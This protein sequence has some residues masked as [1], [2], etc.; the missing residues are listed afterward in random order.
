MG[1][2]EMAEGRG[3][4]RIIKAR[5]CVVQH[6]GQLGCVGNGLK[7]AGNERQIQTAGSVEERTE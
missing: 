2:K 1:G 5:L 6:K 7:I 4:R 3:R